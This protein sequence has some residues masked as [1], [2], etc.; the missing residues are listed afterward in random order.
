MGTDAFLTNLVTVLLKLSDPFMDSEYSKVIVN[1]FGIG[2]YRAIVLVTKI[3]FN[4]RLTKSIWNT[5]VSL[6]E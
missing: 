1:E 3:P 6:T 4:S 2:K 5:S